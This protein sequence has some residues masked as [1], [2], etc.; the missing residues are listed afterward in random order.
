MSGVVL[1]VLSV[2]AAYSRPQL[3]RAFKL[4]ALLNSRRLVLIEPP[5][6]GDR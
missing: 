3:D 5:E 4:A 2:P 1:E 6:L